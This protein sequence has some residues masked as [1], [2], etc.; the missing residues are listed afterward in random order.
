MLWDGSAEPPQLSCWDPDSLIGPDADNKSDDN[1]TEE[2]T[3]LK[4]KNLSMPDYLSFVAMD[5]FSC[6]AAFIS[7]EFIKKCT[8][9]DFN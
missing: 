8:L 7:V 5:K 9:Y 6:L 2:V 1:L 4:N 3:L